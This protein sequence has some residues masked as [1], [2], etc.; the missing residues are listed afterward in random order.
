MS[1]GAPPEPT[2]IRLDTARYFPSA[3]RRKSLGY[4]A[5]GMRPSIWPSEVRIT[6]MALIPPHATY[7]VSPSL[8]TATAFGATPGT[9]LSNGWSGIVRTTAF[10]SVLIT[11][12]ESELLLL[13]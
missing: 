12:T 11:E 10:V 13:T 7:R 4:H 3:L 9:V 8:L 6:A 5:V 2:P 1:A